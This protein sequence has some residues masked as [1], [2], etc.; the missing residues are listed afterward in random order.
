MKLWDKVGRENT[1]GTVKIALEKAEERG[2]KEIV[3]ASNEGD[4]IFSLLQ[5]QQDL[6]FDSLNITC[7]TH[8]VGFSDPGEDEMGAEVRK[9]LKTNTKEIIV[10]KNLDL[11]F[12]L[13]P[14]KIMNSLSTL[15]QLA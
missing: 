11:L 4:T 9:K 15:N 8:R 3:A 14:P 2:I 7:V 10:I 12:K 6:G 5:A 13:I 1:E